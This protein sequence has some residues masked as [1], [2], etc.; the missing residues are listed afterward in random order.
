MNV[1]Q[2]ETFEKAMFGKVRAHNESFVEYT[3]RFMGEMQKYEVDEKMVLPEKLK[4]RL[5]LR[6]ASLNIT[7]KDRLETWADKDGDDLTVNLEML[8]RLDHPRYKSGK[9]GSLTLFGDEDVYYGGAEPL[10]G[11][12]PPWD[13]SSSSWLG[14]E[15]TWWGGDCQDFEESVYELGPYED[16]QDAQHYLAQEHDLGEDS[17]SDT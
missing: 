13:A 16:S 7:Q 10:I 4:V 15:E 3:A 14:P 2:E 12:V 17:C 5:L 11:V 8:N 1:T 9:D 6:R